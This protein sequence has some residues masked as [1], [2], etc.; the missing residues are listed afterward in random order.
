[1]KTRTLLAAALIT[2]ASGLAAAADDGPA[3]PTLAIGAPAPDFDL[4]GVD[5]R[6]HSLKEYAAARVLVI[7]FTCNHCPTAQAYEE[8][9]QKLRDD[10]APKGATLVAISPN[11]PKAVRLGELGYTDLSDFL[12]EMKI[13]PR[14]PHFTFPYPYDG[15]T[16]A[17]GRRCGPPAP[18]H[19]VGVG[20]AP[21][22]R[23]RR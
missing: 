8:R 7:V 6:M 23:C 13:R 20:R 15:G 4:P 21:K 14:E 1:M 3:H 12:G 2:A 17:P 19:G 18:P 11:D 10:F 22:L 5:G 9:I 16:Q